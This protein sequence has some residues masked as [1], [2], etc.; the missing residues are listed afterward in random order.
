MKITNIA[1]A[2]KDRFIAYRHHA[3][4]YLH[5]GHHYAH[6]AYF[7]TLY[8]EGHSL[9]SNI[10]GVLFVLLLISSFVGDAEA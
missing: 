9:Y 5:E 7:G 3:H 4:K 6:L 8:V 10:G 1:K 2:T